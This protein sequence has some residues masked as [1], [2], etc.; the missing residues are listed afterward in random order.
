ME[1][2]GA[3]LVDTPLQLFNA[4]S[5]VLTNAMVGE[6]DLY[7]VKQ[8][9]SA[10]SLAD[11]VKRERIF[12]EVYTLEREKKGK[13]K[14]VYTIFGLVT[15]NLYC[16]LLVKYDMKQKKYQEVYFSAPTKMFDLMI[17]ASNAKVVYGVDDGIGSYM[18]DIFHDY[19][20]AK[21]QTIR[22]I[23]H[24]NYDV[25][26]LYLR[27]P[28]YYIGKNDVKLLQIKNTMQKEC[29][30]KMVE[31]IFEYK[32]GEIY[33]DDSLIYLNQPVGDFDAAH[34]ETEERIAV[35]IKENL[36]SKCIVRLHP[37]ETQ[38]YL[39]DGLK[40]D[41]EQNMWEI[42]CEE[43]IGENN[44][45]IG[46]FSTAQFIPK[47]FYDREPTIVFTFMLYSDLTHERVRGYQEMSLHLKKIYRDKSKVH[48]I[49]SVDELKILLKNF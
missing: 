11:R 23:L 46:M 19:L 26:A 10:D 5:L 21:Y 4:V 12:K 42:L 38:K 39:Y 20:S 29:S 2:K 14:H 41:N 49:G 44:I 1:N 15:P 33:Q 43:N 24:D 30:K 31:R 9:S 25:S 35:L 13:F 18:G 36:A 3:F 47:F 8:F 6:Y 37:R 17:A 45:L 22:K 32:G 34:K 27:T 16:R 48:V 7:L 40:I 28:Q